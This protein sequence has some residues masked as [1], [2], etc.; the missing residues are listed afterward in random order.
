MKNFIKY[1]AYL[2]TRSTQHINARVL[3]LK[4]PKFRRIK[5]AVERN[6]RVSRF[7]RSKLLHGGRPVMFRDQRKE[8]T[9]VKL[10]EWVRHRYYRPVQFYVRFLRK[11][12]GVKTTSSMEKFL[13]RRIT[14]LESLIRRTRKLNAI[15][16]RK[17]LLLKKTMNIPIDKNIVNISV[18]GEIAPAPTSLV[19]VKEP[20]LPKDL[21]PSNNSNK[22][23]GEQPRKIIKTLDPKTKKPRP[24]KDPKDIIDKGEKQPKPAK[25]VKPAKDRKPSKDRKDPNNRD[26]DP[27][28]ARKPSK[29]PK[30]EKVPTKPKNPKP[31]KEPKGEPK[32]LKDRRKEPKKDP[33]PS[34]EPKKP[35]KKPKPSEDSKKKPKPLKD[36]VRPSKKPKEGDKPSKE[37]RKKPSQKTKKPTVDVP[38]TTVVNDDSAVVNNSS[39]IISYDD[40]YDPDGPS[41]AEVAWL[42]DYLDNKEV[43]FANHPSMKREEYEAMLRE[44]PEGQDGSENPKND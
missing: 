41:P 32:P 15:K 35:S 8:T 1:N 29:E 42:Q 24:S 28:K 19:E 36:D 38:S 16:A 23:K 4:R 34:K 5:K 37:P 18:Q 11:R 31:L 43:H 17:K 40:E 39:S 33:A 30:P 13:N 2:K 12:Q 22:D 25:P 7:Y 10:D 6:Y 20:T 27:E 3:N 9:P 21:N 14:N 26:K 44:S